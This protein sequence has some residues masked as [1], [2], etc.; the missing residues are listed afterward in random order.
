[1]TAITKASLNCFLTFTTRETFTDASAELDME[2]TYI[3]SYSTLTH[4][5]QKDPDIIPIKEYRY[6]DS[7]NPF[8]FTEKA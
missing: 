3:Q 7:R 8:Y 6:L 4:F 1:M 2:W 5:L